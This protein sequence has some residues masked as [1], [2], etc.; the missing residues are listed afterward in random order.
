MGL[1]WTCMGLQWTCNCV[2]LAMDLLWTCNCVVGV[3][4]ICNGFAKDLY[5]FA[6]DLLLICM[7]HTAF[8]VWI[9]SGFVMELLWNC[10][11]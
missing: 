7:I 3:Q 1:L 10:M 5:G 8:V 4:W 11:E 6:L 2:G 9:C